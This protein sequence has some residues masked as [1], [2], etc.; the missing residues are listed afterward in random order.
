[1]R[2]TRSPAVLVIDRP[3]MLAKTREILA[4]LHS[5]VS[6]FDIV[7]KLSTSARKV[8]EIAKALV[9]EAKVIIFDEPTASFSQVE[10]DHLFEIIHRLAENK[11]SVIY[12]SHHLEEVFRLADRVTVIR[13]GKKVSTYPIADLTEQKLIHDM[14]GRD[15]S[16]FYQRAQVPVGDEVVLE[17]RQLTGNGVE[18]V[19]FSV[20]KGEILGIAGMDGSGRTE[21][22][23]LLF[24]VKRADSG[25]ILIRGKPVRMK[26]PLSAIQHN[27]C[28][29]TEDR[30]VQGLFLK[31]TLVRNIP[32][33]S[34]VR[35]RTPFALPSEDVKVSEKYVGELQDPHIQPPS[36]RHAA[37]RRQ[38]AESGAGEVV[39]QPGRVLHLRRTDTGD[40]RRGQGGNLPDHGGAAPAGKVDHHDFFRHAG[41]GR[42][43]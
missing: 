20:R 34:Y 7:G 39:C 26:T 1:M 21:L 23:E 10:I 5:D 2:A 15:V 14:V 35:T 37:F 6:P 18:G 28:F 9:Q 22:A 24:G 33:A 27:M 31:H 38:P 32:I 19:S 25:E 30:Q 8:V 13:D 4:Y 3:T 41:A 43:E 42:D 29:I 36:A 17:A 40:R 11:K 12:I 16:L